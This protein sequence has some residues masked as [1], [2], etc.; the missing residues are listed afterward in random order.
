MPFPF[1]APSHLHDC[2]IAAEYCPRGSLLDVLKAARDSPELA[3]K[4][5]WARRLSMAL[6]A[7]KGMM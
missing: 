4:L 1:T 5:K 7:A 3:K 2:P 6:G